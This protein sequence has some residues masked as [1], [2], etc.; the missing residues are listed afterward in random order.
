MRLAN[1][2]QNRLRMLSLS[3]DAAFSQ[4][5]SAARSPWST[6]HCMSA[7]SSGR[8]VGRLIRRVSRLPEAVSGIGR[9]F[10]GRGGR[11]GSLPDVGWPSM[12]SRAGRRRGILPNLVT[13]YDPRRCPL[14]NVFVRVR[15]QKKLPIDALGE[16]AIDGSAQVLNALAKGAAISI[17]LPRCRYS[18]VPGSPR[19]CPAEKSAQAAQAGVGA[20]ST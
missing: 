18:A 4:P 2:E 5:L 20:R 6:R 12:D 3:V 11:G 13:R 16:R 10:S 7:A 8:P 17:H 19:G 9:A 14:P 15:P 1:A